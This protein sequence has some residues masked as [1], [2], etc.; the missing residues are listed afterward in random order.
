MMKKN[1]LFHLIPSDVWKVDWNVNIQPV[2]NA[3]HTIKYLSYYVFKVAI[4]DHRIVNVEDRKV[5]FSH[6]FLLWL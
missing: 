2:G 4:S 1:G 5:T 6:F 3:G